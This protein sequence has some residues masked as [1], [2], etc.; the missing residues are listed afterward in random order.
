MKFKIDFP[1]LKKE[2][3]ITLWNSG[4]YTFDKEIG[5]KDDTAFLIKDI[6]KNCLDKT[7][8]K[9]AFNRFLVNLNNKGC[10]DE[11]AKELGL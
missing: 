10:L 5:R 4:E 7:K 2:K 8:V 11:F 9:K 3:A 6:Q 1:S